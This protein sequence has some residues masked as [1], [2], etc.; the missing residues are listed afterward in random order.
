MR[1]RGIK[2]ELKVLTRDQISKSVAA[3]TLRSVRFPCPLNRH[4]VRKRASAQCA[5]VLRKSHPL[6]DGDSRSDLSSRTGP[7]GLLVLLNKL[8]GG[9]DT[10]GESGTELRSKSD[11]DG[12]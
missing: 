3:K 1:V 12:T 6:R 11:G 2:V 4:G 8:S 9:G 7:P 10:R 5:S